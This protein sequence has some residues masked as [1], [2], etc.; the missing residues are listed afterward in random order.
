MVLG[1][2]TG[3][4]DPLEF[5]TKNASFWLHL[6]IYTCSHTNSLIRLC[7]HEYTCNNLIK[8]DKNNDSSTII[9]N[10][11]MMTPWR[12]WDDSKES[13]D[14]TSVQN[15]VTG[16]EL[17]WQLSHIS[18]VQLQAVHESTRGGE[19]RYSICIALSLT[20]TF[21]PSPNLTGSLF[22]CPIAY[23]HD[24]GSGGPPLFGSKISIYITITLPSTSKS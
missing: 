22:L 18:L 17:V 10:W 24:I 5:K 2:C 15:L 23:L 11:G 3:V 19:W 7:M 13:K 14:L 20:S 12:T 1:I 16:L 6:K 9:F 21:H 8:K 4:Q